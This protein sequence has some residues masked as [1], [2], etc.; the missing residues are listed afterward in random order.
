[1][2]IAMHAWGPFLLFTLFTTMMTIYCFF[3]YPETKGLSMESMDELFT[4]PWYKV[5]RA[6]FKVLESQKAANASTEEKETVDFA[7]DVS[8]PNGTA[9]GTKN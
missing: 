6:S 8:H 9:R 7:E 5:G 4:M 1:M 2:V 3:A